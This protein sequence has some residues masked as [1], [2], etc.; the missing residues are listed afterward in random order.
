M[1]RQHP[2]IT[3]SVEVENNDA[4]SFLDINNI[5]VS[6]KLLRNLYRKETFSDVYT[7][8]DNLVPFG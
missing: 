8:F 3:S 5:G 7:N 6:S 1:N 2:S 4:L